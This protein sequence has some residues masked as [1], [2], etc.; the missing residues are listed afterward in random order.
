MEREAGLN[1]GRNIAIA[2]GV[3]ALGSAA[4]IAFPVLDTAV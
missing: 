3:F 1:L 4:L 2:L